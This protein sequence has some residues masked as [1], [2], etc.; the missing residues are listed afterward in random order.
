MLGLGPLLHT[1]ARLCDAKVTFLI[2]GKK[3]KTQSNGQ[4]TTNMWSQ[5]MT[6]GSSGFE[7][8]VL[9]SALIPYSE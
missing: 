2:T 6:P 8:H 4:I 7:V 9:T 5:D 1:L 3:P